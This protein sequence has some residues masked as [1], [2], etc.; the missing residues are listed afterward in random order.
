MGMGGASVANGFL[1]DAAPYNPASILNPNSSKSTG[2]LFNISLAIND[3]TDMIDAL[4]TLEDKAKDIAI[5]SQSFINALTDLEDKQL[6]LSFSKFA[7]VA[8]QVGGERVKHSGFGFYHLGFYRGLAAVGVA[9]T[10]LDPN[11][12]SGTT[13]YTPQSA[14]TFMSVKVNETGISYSTKAKGYARG[15]ADGLHFGF[16][17]KVQKVEAY[18]LAVN[19]SDSTYEIPDIKDIFNGNAPGQ[20]QSSTEINFD[21][22]LT[23][24]NKAGVRL[25]LVMTNLFAK[26]VAIPSKE[27]TSAVYM[28]EPILTAGAG[29]YSQF[30]RLG[31]ELDLS[32]RTYFEGIQAGGETIKSLD[33]EQF[34]SFGAEFGSD[35]FAF[36]RFGFQHNLIK[37]MLTSNRVTTGMRLGAS[38]F[39]LDLSAFVGLPSGKREVGTAFSFGTS[40]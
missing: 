3:S 35:H 11:S 21:L 40:F 4:S 23:Y 13:G 31:I 24:D 17:A 32:K 19:A 22:G 9:D 2:I 26:T 37:D 30:V 20:E 12:Y 36:F 10:D 15:F 5:D 39:Y 29:Y 7:S 27:K 18:N 1:A 38:I 16:T 25:G 8:F 34:V 14:I 6:E 28:I 33:D